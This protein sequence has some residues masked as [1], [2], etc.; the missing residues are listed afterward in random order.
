MRKFK[1]VLA[2]LLALVLVLGCVGTAFAAKTPVSEIEGLK[3]SGTGEA[4]GFKSIE[5]SKNINKYNDDDIVRAIVSL[6]AAPTSALAKRGAANEATVREQVKSSQDKVRKAMRGI[7][8]ELEYSFD[9][10]F[11]GFSCDV[12]YGDL[13]KIA[14]IDGVDAV[15]IANSYAAPVVEKSRQT[16]TAYSAGLTGVADA[17]E[18]FGVDGSGIVIAVL[19]TGLNTTHEAFQ[20]ADGSCAAT[21]RLTEADV[22]RTAAAGKYIN[23]KVPFAYDY[24]DKDNDVTDH[25][26]HGTHVSGI[27]AGCAFDTESGEYTF[28]GAAPCAQIVSMKIFHDNEG[29]TTSDIYLYA[30]EDAYRLGVDV[31]NMSIGAQNG[32]TYDSELETEAFGNIYKR[33]SDSGIILSVAAGNEY[34]MA[35]NSTKGYLGP[36]YQDY[37][38]VGTPSTYIGSTSVASVENPRYLD[39]AIAVD[40][41]LYGYNDSCEDE[42]LMWRNV[43]GDKTTDFVVLPD[44]TDAND[45]SELGLGL[46]EEFAAVNVTGKI[47]VM[48][49]GNLSF[50]EKV[51]NAANAGAI[52]C[53]IVNNEATQLLMSIDTFEIPAICANVNS[54]NAFLNA[55]EKT[56]F[57]TN[58]QRYITNMNAG[59]MS[60]FSNWG[61]SPML[62]IAPAITSVGG[63]VYSAVNTGDHDYAD[64]SGTSMAAPN[65][66][67][68][69]A[70]VLQFLKEYGKKAEWNADESADWVE[71]T[72]VD[73]AERALSLL[74]GSATIITD[75]DGYPYSVRKQGA[76]L[77]NVYD[78]LSAYCDSGYIVDPIQELGDDA[79]KQGIYR[80]DVTLTNESETTKFFMPDSAL[81]YDFVTDASAGTEYEPLLVNTRAE[82]ILF[83]GDYDI[84]YSIDGEAVDGVIG[85]ESGTTCTVSV[86]IKLSDEVKT[87]FDQTFPNGNYIDGF[88]WFDEVATDASGSPLFHD[89]GDNLY[90][91]DEE[92]DALCQVQYDSTAADFVFLV[93]DGGEK[94]PCP[95]E[96]LDS[97]SMYYLSSAHVSLLAFYGDWT[98][99]SVLE[100]QD[101]TDLIKAIA[102][103]GRDAYEYLDVYTDVNTVYNAVFDEDG[104][105]TDDL[106]GYLGDNLLDYVD[107][108]PEHN[109]FSTEL[110]DADGFYGNGIY[111]AP[112]LLRNCKSLKMTVSDAETGEVYY[113]DDT[114]YVR[115]AYF[116]D[117]AQAWY[118]TCEYLWSGKDADGEFVPSGTIANIVFD[119]V[120]PYG[121]TL[122]E[123]VWSFP[124]EVDYEA[125]VLESVEYNDADKTLTVTASDESYLASIY[126]YSAAVKKIVDSESFSSDE[127]GKSF[128][129]VFDVADL[130]E[131]GLTSLD[132]CAIDYAT[133]EVSVTAPLYEVG[134]DATITYVTPNNTKTVAV[135][136]GDTY[137]VEDCSE[138]FDDAQFVLWVDQEVEDADDDTIYDAVT[139][140]YEAGDQLT[141]DGDLTLY[142]LYAYGEETQLETPNYYYN[143]VLDYSGD[144]AICGLDYVDEDYDTANPKALNEAGETKSVADDLGGTIGDYYIEFY[145]DET[146]IRFTFEK[147]ADNIYTI[148]N[149][150]TG[151]YLAIEGN[152]LA[153]LDTATDAAR[154]EVT[155]DLELDGAVIRSAFNGRWILAYNDDEGEFQLMD[156]TVALGSFLGL[157]LRPSDVYLNW[158]YCYSDTELDTAGYTTKPTGECKHSGGEATCTAQAIC[159]HCGQPY[160]E[161]NPDNH[162]G[163]PEWIRTETTH[164]KKY[165]CCGVVVVAEEAHEW[166]DGVCSECGYGC[167]HSGGEATCTARAICEHCGQSYGEKNPD[168]HAGKAEWSCTETTHEKKYDCCGVVAVAKEAH[169]WK[170]GVCTECGYACKHKESDTEV[171]N[172]KAATITEDGYTGDVVC[173]LCGTLVKKGEVI[174]ATGYP[175]CHFKDFKDC[176]SAWY[177][178]AVDYT[179]DKSLMKGITKDT[180]DP[181]G[182]MTRAMMV[183]VLYRMA[184][185]SAVKGSSTFTDVPAGQ[186]Y[187]DAITWAQD[188][189]IV[190]GVLNDKFAPD[191]FVT[192][193][194]IAT[195]LWRYAGKPAAESKF[196]GFK[197]ADKISAYAKEAMAWAVNEG[198][199]NGDGGN[200]KPAANA[201][202]AEFA[203]IVM[204]YLDGTYACKDLKK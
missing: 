198:I 137:T 80:F 139:A 172:A 93:S 25:Q 16:R 124:V 183:T 14:S 92:S 18:E 174:P 188:N 151:K 200:L 127:E 40:G 176:K 5:F 166:V 27:A 204:R 126:L 180:F 75:E 32:F 191:D 39:Y 186:W 177:H 135:K 3:K 11:N 57:T 69:A 121:D 192:R 85:V 82:D 63:H 149:F 141:V 24:A 100:Q 131:A 157:S 182:T 22:T 76:G 147:V 83:E 105:M 122:V 110:T 199:L 91:Y 97:L 189:G 89:D 49:R 197:D 66:A 106:V 37:G 74:E 120:L 8:Y 142:A 28:L 1:S 136:T 108:Y 10:L 133:N 50:E 90:L 30:L 72:K 77:A 185:S 26:G 88:V 125:P 117:E 54:V 167:T 138:K 56:V 2:L 48:Q 148:K 29:G 181:N 60:D 163:E 34:S 155:S 21:G 78:A 17:R 98:Q 61:T 4:K 107:Y 103:Y 87:K 65:F 15:Y 158:L 45:Y 68:S 44:V 79:E 64:Y 144:W 116:E 43:F 132:V 102:D 190:L 99:G 203:C 41:E 184:G 193:E 7:D 165:D 114:P 13:D 86:E 169:E 178:E 59:L 123:K 73:R 84:S 109:A 202:R 164:E 81:L 134:K 154:W 111:I 71:L 104:K 153:F 201:T 35:D 145:T 38:T 161:K 23:A 171:K 12:A 160:G 36:E 129:A 156:D 47:A 170:D 113:V 162:S 130:V 150:K 187:S 19:D 33:L 52:G 51:E 152:A 6:E 58:D 196:D 112:Y 55:E 173:K 96:A 31:I 42:S 20:D 179:V 115:K 159:E 119:A 62:T 140:M 95:E 67:G 128:T 53:I 46:P 94:I 195:I 194:Q 118:Y 70:L 146:G 175:D 143:V 168:N 101:F 9:T